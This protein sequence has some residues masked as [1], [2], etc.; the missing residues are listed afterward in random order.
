MGPADSAAWMQITVQ[1]EVEPGE[2][3]I[4]ESRVGGQN[5]AWYDDEGMANTGANCTAPGVTPGIGSRYGSTYRSV[6]GSKRAVVTPVFGLAG[7]YRVFA[8]WGAGSSRRSPITYHVNHAFGTQTMQ[9]D[10]TATANEWIELGSDPYYF[11]KGSSGSVEMTNEDIDVSGSMFASAFKFEYIPPVPSDKEYDVRGIPAGAAN[12]IIDGTKGANEWTSAFPEATGFVFH[13]NPAMD[14]SE[15]ASFQMLYD[16]DHLYILF[17]MENDYMAGFSAPAD[18][19][20]YADLP[21]DKINF[22]ITPY[23]TDTAPFFRVLFAPNPSDGVCYVWSQAHM[24]RTTSA[25]EGTDW[26]PAGTAAFGYEDNRLVLEYRIAWS[27][28]ATAD[29]DFSSG[30]EPGDQW[31]VQP[32]LTNEVTRGTWEYTNWEPDDTPGYIVGNPMGALRFAAP[33]QEL[34][35]WRVR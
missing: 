18:P 27:E 7:N 34:S 26:K 16:E 1:K 19:I 30:P 25:D 31:G 11:A 14:S 33:G 24:T 21:G 32:A 9:L 10:Q 12:P 35:A 5:F 8:A 17:E 23:G 3:F 2:D 28:F 4:V 22:Y 29:M 13:N 15:A 20:E 6:A